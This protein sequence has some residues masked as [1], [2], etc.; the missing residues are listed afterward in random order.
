MLGP[1]MRLYR[2]RDAL[3]EVH[4]RLSESLDAERKLAEGVQMLKVDYDNL[5]NRL[6]SAT[7]AHRQVDQEATSIRFFRD[8]ASR[9]VRD[10]KEVAGLSTCSYC[11]QKLTATHMEAEKVRLNTNLVTYENQLSSATKCLTQAEEIVQ[12]ILN[13]KMTVE[14]LLTA[15]RHQQYEHRQHAVTHRRDQQ[16]HAQICQQIYDEELDDLWRSRVATLSPIDWLSTS[17]PAQTDLERMQQNLN[18]LSAV[19]ESLREA[20]NTHE[21]VKTLRDRIEF[22][23]GSIAAQGATLFTAPDAVRGDY[24]QLAI[25]ESNFKRSLI[26]SREAIEREGQNVDALTAQRND[27]QQRLSANQA[28]LKEVRAQQTYSQIQRS[29]HRIGLPPQFQFMSDNLSAIEL[30]NLQLEFARLAE[31]NLDVRFNESL[32]AQANVDSLGGLILHLERQLQEVP[33][34]ARQ[35]VNEIERLLTVAC[36]QHNSC[37]KALQEAQLRA[38][39]LIQTHSRRRQLEEAYLK[40]SKDHSLYQILAELLGPRQ[41]QREL[42]RRA[43]REIVDL[44][45]VM[46][47]RVSGGQLELILAGQDTHD[48]GVDRHVLQL[49]VRNRSTAAEPLGVAFL[50]GSQRFRVAV[51]LALGMGQY[52]SARHR[53]IQSVI[54]DEGFGSLDREGRQV[55]IHELQNLRGHLERIVLVSHQEEFAD[56]FPD[57]YRF[58]LKDGATRV[59]RFHG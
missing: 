37:D 10:F 41:L 5:T 16:R 56:A 4:L 34:E 39:R 46:L 25:E 42:M 28:K 59:T 32:H 6:H 49:A 20:K 11:G 26:E 51:S 1:L 54:I 3:R 33:S 27:A 18:R 15:A 53:S 21:S 38:D 30:Q 7:I 52:A 24:E 45:N 9:R 35:S 23:G 13:E 48:D 12:R 55:M 14:G 36:H 44:A 17:Y 22:I 57:G 19:R 29:E 58:E 31:Q 2:E 40:V 8:Q 50:S 43:E 47:D